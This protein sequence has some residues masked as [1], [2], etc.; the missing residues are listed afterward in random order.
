[1]CGIAGIFAYGAA[2]P[3]VDAE[4]LLRIRESMARRGPDGSGLWISDDRRVGMA[5]RRLAIIELSDAGAQ[6]M[7]SD[8]GTLTITFN[9]EIYNYREL[10]AQLEARGH[11]FR[12][13]SDTEV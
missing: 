7:S 6:P 2:S 4:E 5:H 10:R 9:G 11:R 8:D 13:T 1:M 3:A 12:S